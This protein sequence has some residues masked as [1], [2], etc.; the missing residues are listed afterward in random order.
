MSKEAEIGDGVS[1][2]RSRRDFVVAVVVLASD[3]LVFELRVVFGS[4]MVYETSTYG[5]E[6]CVHRGCWGLPACVYI[7][8][9]EYDASN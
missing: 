2:G 9:H 4:F 5:Y 1:S 8:I 3:A 6:L 7:D